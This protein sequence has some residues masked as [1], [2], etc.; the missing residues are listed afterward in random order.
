MSDI[1]CLTSIRNYLI[2]PIPNS[3]RCIRQNKSTQIRVKLWSF[4]SHTIWDTIWLKFLSKNNYESH[5]K[6]Y[7]WN[8]EQTKKWHIL[9]GKD[10]FN[11]RRILKIKRYYQFVNHLPAARICKNFEKTSSVLCF[12]RKHYYMKLFKSNFYF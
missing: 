2:L 7:N 5:Q 12:S 4:L 10:T 8:L 9:S 11:T 6:L 1:T 3:H